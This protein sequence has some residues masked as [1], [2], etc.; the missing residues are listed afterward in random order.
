MESIQNSD[1]I[2]KLVALCVNKSKF[3]RTTLVNFQVLL[4]YSPR[5]IPFNRACRATAWVFM[6]SCLCR[7]SNAPH[8]EKN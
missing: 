1:D 7:T 5:K 4:S 8:T 2:P 6:A 3:D